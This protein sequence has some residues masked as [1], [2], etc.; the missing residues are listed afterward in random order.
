MSVYLDHNA[1]TP[2]DERV[3]EAMLPFLGEH[4]GNPSSRHQAG[5]IARAAVDQARQQVAALV[6]AHPSQVVFTGGGSE[7]NNLALFGVAERMTPGL[8]AVSRVEHSSVRAPAEVLQQRGWQLQ[9]IDIDAQGNIDGDSLQA[10]LAAKPAMLALMLANNETGVIND[11]AAVAEMARHHGAMVLSDAVQAAGKMELDFS[12]TGAHMM[13]VSAHKI[14]GPKGVGALIVDK[15]VDM[16]PLVYGGGHEKG[17]RAGTENVA[18]IVGFGKA[19]E[20][21]IAELSARHEHTRLLRD[22]LEQ[23]LVAAIP[24]VVIFAQHAQRLAN[25]SFFAVPGLDGETLLMA[26][27][28]GGFAVSSG[29]ACSSGDTK[30]SHVLQAMGVERELARGAIRVSLGKDNNR[31]EIDRFVACLKQQVDVLQSFGSLACA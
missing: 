21:A 16:A 23:T 18:G 22:H 17:R 27:D 5:R 14:H 10:V 15:A 7:A 28:Q 20:L 26:L 8:L 24:S 12:A 25:C 29:S 9:E 19:A 11:V 30:P 4:C 31:E 1:T 13:S 6:K 2:L 3:L